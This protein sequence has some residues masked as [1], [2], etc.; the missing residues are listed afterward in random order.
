MF[1]EGKISQ[2]KHETSKDLILIELAKVIQ[3]GWPLQHADLNPDWYAFWI[4][5]W[6]L[7]IVDGVIMNGTHIVI[8]ESL[9]GEY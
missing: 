9:Q 3:A 7:S 8:P 4:H 6:N 2:V 5:H 1:Q